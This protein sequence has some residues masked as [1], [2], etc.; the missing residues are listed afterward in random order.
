MMQQ[1]RTQ[2]RRTHRRPYEQPQQQRG[3]CNDENS[4][5]KL[6]V[7]SG[8][9]KEIP[10]F[11]R[12]DSR[13]TAAAQ[14]T[15]TLDSHTMRRRPAQ[16]IRQPIGAAAAAAAGCLASS[17][18]AAT[19]ANSQRRRRTRRQR[20]YSTYS[21]RK[22]FTQQMMSQTRQPTTDQL[23]ESVSGQLASSSLARELWIQRMGPQAAIE[24]PIAV[25]AAA[26][27]VA[28][29]KTTTP[30]NDAMQV[31]RSKS[32]THLWHWSDQDETQEVSSLHYN[33]MDSI[34]TKRES[35]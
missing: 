8:G 1:Q 22:Y 28:A 23:A 32:K 14:R 4:T 29:T 16:H 13:E 31:I 7:R 24:E 9:A 30:A 11:A 19:T 26:A 34:A 2:Q 17:A 35:L 12:R 27:A 25:V 33:P 20:P 10:S 18:T 6:R 5:K 21:P 15:A 3:N